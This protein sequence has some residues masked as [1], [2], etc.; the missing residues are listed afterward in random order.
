[1]SETAASRAV[2]EVRRELTS[3]SD[4]TA[5]FVNTDMVTH[6]VPAGTG[7]RVTFALESEGHP[8]SVTVTQTPT[9]VLSAETV[10]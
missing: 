4:G 2:R 7:A 5:V 10:T 6:V 9:Q 1:M 8:V 3:A